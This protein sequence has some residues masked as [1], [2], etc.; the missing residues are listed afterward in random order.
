MYLP[1][2]GAVQVAFSSEIL[3]YLSQIKERF[4]SYP[5]EAVSQFISTYALR[6][7]EL[8]AQYSIVGKRTIRLDQLKH[9]LD[10]ADSFSR[11]TDFE[12]WVLQVA[13]EQ[14]NAHSDLRLDYRKVK[15]GRTIVAIEFSPVCMPSPASPRENNRARTLGVQ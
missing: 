11:F 5:L 10:C 6:L 4:T 12:R 13:A 3:P 2:Q 9:W 14:I 15:Q 7:Y 8:L 1:G